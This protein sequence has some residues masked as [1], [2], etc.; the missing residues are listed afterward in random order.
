MASDTWVWCEAYGESCRM[1]EAREP[2]PWLPEMVEVEAEPVVGFRS[3]RV[4]RSKISR[5]SIGSESS[6]VT[7]ERR[8]E[9]SPEDEEDA[10]ESR[11]DRSV[12]D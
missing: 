11:M 4:R 5:R 12:G 10:H 6:E 1:A 9:G 8:S 7:N 3:P 2:N